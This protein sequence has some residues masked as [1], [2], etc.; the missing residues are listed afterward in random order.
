MDDSKG[1][2]GTL[3]GGELELGLGKSNDGEVRVEERISN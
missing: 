2:K 3:V 1:W